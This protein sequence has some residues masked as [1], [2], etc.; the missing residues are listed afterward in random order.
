M[1]SYSPER[2]AAVL[3]KMLPP[4]N[5]SIGQ[6]SRQE[7]IPANTL[8]GWRSQAGITTQPVADNGK[9]PQE[10]SQNARFRYPAFSAP[11]R[12]G[13]QQAFLVGDVVTVQQFP[14][15]FGPQTP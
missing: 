5:Q 11:R 7:S 14:H 15:L 4:H 6:L 13:D 9:P 1:G 10:W 3:A 2:K 12:A 8:Y